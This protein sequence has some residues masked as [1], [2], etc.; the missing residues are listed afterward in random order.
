MRYAVLAI[1]SALLVATETTVIPYIAIRG[2]APDIVMSFVILVGMLAGRGD[3]VFVGLIAGLFEDGS[4]GQFLGLFMATRL[5]VGYIAGTFHRK[6]FQDWIIVPMILVFLGGFLGGSLHIFLLV[7]F[8]VPVVLSGATLRMVMLQAAYSAAMTPVLL[9]I[10]RWL[11]DICAKHM[12]E[13][14]RF[15]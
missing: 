5:I 15:M 6:V 9:R 12:R 2:V 8:G 13:R 11:L 7:S 3:A 1:A 14:Q 4:S 10:A